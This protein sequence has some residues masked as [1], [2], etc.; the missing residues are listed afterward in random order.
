MEII[1]VDLESNISPE[2]CIALGN[3]DGMHLGH[4]AL[5]REVRRMAKAANMSASVLIFKEHTKNTLHGGR[6]NLLTL[7]EQKYEILD[8]CGIDRVYEM[9]FTREIMQLSPEDFVL[10]FLISHL[11]IRGVVVGYDYRFGHM[12]AGNVEKMEKLCQSGG[13]DLSVIRPV[14]Y[15]SEAVSSTRIRNAVRE[16]DILSATGMLGRPY[17]IRGSVQPGKQLGRTIGIPT[18]NVHFPDDYIVPKF[19][20]YAAKVRI[21][22]RWHDAATSIGTNPTFSEQGIK[23]E[24]Y[25]YDYGG[26]EFYG[27]VIDI[28]LVDYIRPEIRFPDVSSLKQQM[29]ADLKEIPLRIRDRQFTLPP[30]HAKM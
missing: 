18:A 15:G 26:E 16:G 12:A 25:L 8:A 7:R 9:D 1:Q 21:D 11:K 5:I 19:G 14:L 23:I 22:D 13:I 24:S 29:D 28:A 20:V 6:Q 30:V 17:T 10:R 3:F 27:K 4:Q 2:T